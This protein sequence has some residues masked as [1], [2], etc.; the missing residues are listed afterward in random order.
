L[1]YGLTILHGTVP[2]TVPPDVNKL[3][4]PYRTFIWVGG[5]YDY[6]R[7]AVTGAVIPDINGQPVPH[8]QAGQPEWCFAYGEGEWRNGQTY[9]N[10]RNAALGSIL[11]PPV[12][13]IA[14]Q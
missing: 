9:V 6:V 4:L 11:N 1:D 7:D 13:R 3:S 12:G 14:C 8:P 2:Q 10:V 5:R